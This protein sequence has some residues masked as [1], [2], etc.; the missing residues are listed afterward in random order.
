MKFGFRWFGEND[1]VKLSYAKQIPALS[2]IVTSLADKPVGAVWEKEEIHKRKS[3]IENAGFSWDVI[4]SIPLHEEIKHRGPNRKGYIENY[5]NSIR[6]AG[7][8][9]ISTLCY[10][11]MPVFDWMRTGLDSPLP[12]GSLS[13]SFRQKELDKIDILK[14]D[15]N[16]PAWFFNYE[17]DELKRLVEVYRE[18]SAEDLW[19]SLKGFLDEIIPVAEEVG[20]N[21]AIHPD[22][23]PWSIFGLPRII[24]DGKALKRLVSLNSAK[25]NGI[26]LCTGSLGA[27][28]TNKPQDFIRSTELKGRLHFVHLRNLRHTEGRDFYETSHKDDEG[29]V[30][31][32][33]VLRALKESDF[34]GVLR[35]DHGRHIW[36]DSGLP[37][38]GFYDRALG[39]SYI[40][41][42]WDAINKG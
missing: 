2:S 13:M 30:D 14:M 12:D 3:T 6:K 17:E 37:G 10:N 26:T 33:D 36:D 28:K 40:S 15:L 18:M 35:P 7:Q 34:K 21:M 29:S 42:A 20:V 27:L 39:L 8:A 19:A 23:P 5:K 38:Y 32:I 4:E 22:D 11:F 1:P 41:G 16:R 9:G 25:A 24:T 31:V